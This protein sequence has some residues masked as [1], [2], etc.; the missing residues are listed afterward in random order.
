MKKTKLLPLIFLLSVLALSTLVFFAANASKTKTSVV[1]SLNPYVK[2]D[3]VDHAIRILQG[4]SVVINDTI[5]LNATQA[6]TVTEYSLGF[7]YGYKYNLA[8]VYAFNTSSP[9]QTFNVSLDTGLGAYVGFYGVTVIFPQNGIQLT[10]GESFRFT[11]AF[12]FSDIISSST[13]TLPNEEVPP[14]NVTTPVI[15][16]GFPM[17]PSLNQSASL[18]NVTIFCP[19]KIAFGGDSSYP[20]IGPQQIEGTTDT[21]LILGLTKTSLERLTNAPG[22]MNFTM[23]EGYTYQVVDFDSLNRHVDIDEFGN[24][25]VSDI[26]TIT[27]KMPKLINGIQ[28]GLL[29][30]AKNVSAYNAQGELISAPQL[31]D[32]NTTTYSVNFGFAVN[33]GDSTQFKLTYSLPSSDYLSKTGTS[34]FA[35]N[36]PITKGLDRVAK[37][38]TFSMSLPE[39]ASINQYPS[40]NSYTIQKE[41]L[42]QEIF[43]TAYNASSYNSFDLQTTYVYSVFWASFR[44]TLWITA[45]VA[46]AVAVALVWQRSKPTLVLPSPGV[47]AKPQILKSVVS[48]Y[49]ERTRILRELESI[50]R[51]VQK[52]KLPRRRYKVR[53]RMLESQ[54]NRLDRELVDLKQRVKSVGPKYAEI[55]KELDITE[56]ELEGVQAEEKRVEAR[57]RSGNLTLDAYRRLQDQLNKRREKAKTTI[58]GALLRL[59][60][61]MA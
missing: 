30:G 7:P 56:A 39:G 18:V 38:L 40:L 19:P 6:T 11:V 15:T 29:P 2:V 22:W 60:E 35:T 4:G 24:M 55:L 54:M 42:Q 48:S 61:G 44:P 25:F 45:I 51:Q 20:G 27:N 47:T 23:S 31:S 10:S 17:Y 12:V 5:H 13:T 33:E 34:D 43:F 8:Y 49:E 28:L 21:G 3:K 14:K 16:T 37:K 58:D 32:K 1:A 26:Y 53:K 46:I 50:E 57:Y 52:G 59:S 41:A 36:F 9:S